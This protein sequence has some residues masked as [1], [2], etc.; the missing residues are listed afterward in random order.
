MRHSCSQTPNE[1]SQ[2]GN[3]NIRSADQPPGAWLSF[4]VGEAFV[5][6]NPESIMA[7]AVLWMED[8]LLSHFL[9]FKAERATDVTPSGG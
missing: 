7:D 8:I 2:L 1:K 5:T 4:Q 3:F 6:G 9:M